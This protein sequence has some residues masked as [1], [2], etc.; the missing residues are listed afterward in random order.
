MSKPDDV[1]AVEP[2]DRQQSPEPVVDVEWMNEPVPVSVAVETLDESL[3]SPEV[4][5]F[6]SIEELEQLADDLDRQRRQIAELKET[7]E[8]LVAIVSDD[9]AIEWDHFEGEGPPET[10]GFDED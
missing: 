10:P 4:G 2:G 3:F 7:F 5:I 6:A 9:V 8:E 1:E